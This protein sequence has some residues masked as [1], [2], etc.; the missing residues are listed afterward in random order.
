[1][2]RITALVLCIL[3]LIAAAVGCAGGDTQPDASGTPS[4]AADGTDGA[5]SDEAAAR[6][7][8]F[9]AY[10]ADTVIV[11][12]NGE[13]IAWGEFGDWL[14]YAVLA[15]EGKYGKVQDFSAEIAEGMTYSDYI[16]SS[17]AGTVR[18]YM[19]LDE[20]AEE[21]GVSLDEATQKRVDESVQAARDA[22]ESEDA[23]EEAVLTVYSSVEQYRYVIEKSTLYEHTFIEQFGEKG[24]KLPEQDVFDYIEGDGHMM[25]KHILLKSADD[26]GN[27]YSEEELADRRARMEGFIAELDACEDRDAMLL[28]FDEL[29]T[30]NTEDPG[31]AGYPNGYLFQSGDMVP[32]FEGEVTSLGE[33]EYSGI[34]ESDHGYHLIL[35]L[36]IDVDEVPIRYASLYG[37][38]YTLRRVIAESIFSDVISGRASEMTLEPTE[39]FEELD[40]SKLFA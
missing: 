14:Y 4:G 20:H 39:T 12:I 19:A 26:D 6:E 38:E 5:T 34:V 10:P 15:F 11:K 7:F 3:M 2:K 40:L 27:A 22:Y 21:F 8:D 29:M 13:D 18:Y 1:M 28:K 36:P 31:L 30:A 9:D 25:A 23:F 32:E 35:R 16:L 24:A 33:Y 37:T 17:A